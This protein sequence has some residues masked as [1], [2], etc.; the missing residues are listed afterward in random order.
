M[1]S[2]NAIQGTL[3]ADNA[4]TA[5]HI[6]SNAVASIQIAE[7]NVTAR[8]IA[9]NTITVAQL[10]D[11]CVESD[12]IADGV[13][14]TNHLNKAMISSQTEVAVATGDFILLGD[15]SDSNNLKK[16]PISSIL[17]GTL[18]TAA[19]TNITSVGTLTSLGVDGAATFN[20]SGADVNF[21][22]ESDGLE[23]MFFVDAGNNRVAINHDAPSGIF[24]VAGHTSSVASIFESNGNGDT[25]PVQLKVK[26]NNGTTSTQGLYGNAGSASTDN[27]ITLGGSG[28][29]GVIVDNGGKVGINTTPDTLLN[30]KDTGGIEVRLEADSNNNGQEDCFIRFYTDGKTQE[31]IAGMDNNN[32]STLFSGNT[33][34]AMVFGTVSN[35]PVVLATNNT[36][37]FQISAAGNVGI[38]NASPA[39]KLH[40]GGNVRFSTTTADSNESRFDFTMG[41]A[42]DDPIMTMY[43]HDG[44]SASVK[45]RPGVDN[46]FENHVL[47][48][49]TAT[50]F[51]SNNGVKLINDGRIAC[52]SSYTSNSQESYAMYSTGVSNWRFYVGWAGRIS[53]V[54]TSINQISDERLKENILDIDTGLAEICALKPRR[55]DW[56]GNEGTGE[57]G[58]QGF[59]AQEVETV[60]PELVGNFKHNTLAD[61]KSVMMG[62]AFPT[63]VKA[64]QELKAENDALK[65]RIETLEE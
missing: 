32:S 64:I 49:T 50:S 31:G 60:M 46:Y 3:I 2:V 35:L 10:A 55:F 30:L 54:T 18:T 53:A 13:I 25:V 7:N 21:R 28:T 58:V 38:G 62:D 24:H 63:V 57:K 4:I 14:T 48:G 42:A 65:A 16:A 26:A 17:A 23:Y 22:I 36:E 43:R 20:E 40:V 33:E 5:V 44:V 8:E 47:V 51:S 1:V 41:G 61:C 15:T 12:K 34:N 45:L 11:D 39:Q 59:I 37:R 6:A 27:T 19:Q 56:K 29:S 52:V 9:A